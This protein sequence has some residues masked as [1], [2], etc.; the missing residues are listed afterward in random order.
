MHRLQQVFLRR[1]MKTHSAEK[2]NKCGQCD[3]ACSDPRSLVRHTQRREIKQ[4]QPLW[5]CIPWGDVKRHLKTHNGEKSNKC[6]QC[7]FSCT[8]IWKDT[9]EKSRTNATNVTLSHGLW[10]DIQKD[11]VYELLTIN[12]VFIGTVK[13]SR[14]PQNWMIFF[15]FS[16][17]GGGGGHFRSKNFTS[18]HFGVFLG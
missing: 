12:L 3:F 18:V 8:D 2:A 10:G 1:H 15:S 7:D 11:T 16:K 4:M 9:V 17:H 14:E 5:L 13:V 6:R